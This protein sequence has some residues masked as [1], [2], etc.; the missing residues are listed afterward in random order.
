MITFTDVCDDCFNCCFYVEN[1]ES[2][3]P[4]YGDSERCD[5]FIPVPVG[6]VNDGE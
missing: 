5:E 2:E 1:R 3:N 4:C 6:D